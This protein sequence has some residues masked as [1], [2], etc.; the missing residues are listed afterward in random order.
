MNHKVLNF[1]GFHPKYNSNVKSILA[2]IKNYKDLNKITAIA[3]V[4]SL[5]E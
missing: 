2:D 3:M 1:E 4:F 5:L